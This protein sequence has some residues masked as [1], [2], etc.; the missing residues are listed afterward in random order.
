MSHLFESFNLLDRG[1]DVRQLENHS[2]RSVFLWL[3]PLLFMLG[4]LASMLVYQF[5][6]QHRVNW[7][8]VVLLVNLG[9]LAFRSARI[10]YRRIN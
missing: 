6:R 8:A 7:L 10:V 9:L 3:L 1:W 4:M 5:V 2:L